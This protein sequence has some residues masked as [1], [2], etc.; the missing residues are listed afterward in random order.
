MSTTV[1][2][3]GWKLRFVLLGPAIMLLCLVPRTS[4][5]FE[6][7]YPANEQ[8]RRTIREVWERQA[9]RPPE[10]LEQRLRE[11]LRSIN[12]VEGRTDAAM[13]DRLATELKTAWKEL[14]RARAIGALGYSEFDEEK[15]EAAE[16]KLET[17]AAQ[18]RGARPPLPGEGYQT[19]VQALLD[20]QAL[21]RATRHAVPG[22]LSD[23]VLLMREKR[24]RLLI[25]EPRG[26]EG[27]PAR[28][29]NETGPP[30]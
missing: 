20:V 5:S 8:L 16:S 27:L 29:G 11:A 14:E 25:K 7:H 28:F 3:G 19:V 15:F 2:N 12:E 30:R 9:V 22:L 10:G 18:F 13:A 24:Q 21:S 26:E 23:D 1:G 6:P 4:D 17:I